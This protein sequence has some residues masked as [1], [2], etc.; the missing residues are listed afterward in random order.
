M[1]G[2][3]CWRRIATNRERS[4]A[5]IDCIS[6]PIARSLTNRARFPCNSRLS[7]SPPTFWQA[8]PPA[9]TGSGFPDFL[10]FELSGKC[11]SPACTGTI[12][13]VHTA[14]RTHTAQ[15]R[16]SQVMPFLC[17]LSLLESWKGIDSA[18]EVCLLGGELA[19]PN[20]GGARQPLDRQLRYYS[21][22]SRLASKPSRTFRRGNPEREGRRTRPEAESI[23]KS[24]RCAC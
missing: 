18:G 11:L 1:S 12:H 9:R 16:F 13:Q 23:D 7:A 19:L 5:C 20:P 22:G 24:M 15:R 17:E 4:S 3:R 10:Y 14:L 2:I 8:L 21:E 6:G